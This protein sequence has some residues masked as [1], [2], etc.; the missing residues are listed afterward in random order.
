M[1]RD[2]DKIVLVVVHCA[3][4]ADGDPAFDIRDVNQWHGAP[5]HGYNRDPR[6]VKDLGHG[7]L[8]HIAYQTFIPTSGEPQQ[9]R[10]LEEVGAHCA[11]YNAVSVG[12][13][14]A[15]KTA[16]TLPQWYTLRSEIVNLTIDLG[17]P[18][19]IVGHNA[20]DRRTPPK[21]CPG[22]DVDSWLRGGMAPLPAHLIS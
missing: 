16:F 10:L 9:G 4:T 7:K 13:C 5:P 20:L 1:I 6:L 15:G 22:F 11:G 19:R 8:H 3:D 18:L 12:I 14:M 21:T 2:L 17:R